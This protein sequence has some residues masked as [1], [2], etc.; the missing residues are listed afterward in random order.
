MTRSPVKPYGI[1]ISACVQATSTAAISAGQTTGTAK[2]DGHSANGLTT[3][4]I[5]AMAAAP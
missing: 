3:A 4:H 1:H 5:I 2:L